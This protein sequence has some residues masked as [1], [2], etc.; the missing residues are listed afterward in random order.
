MATTDRFRVGEK[1][2]ID[3]VAYL[4]YT[5]FK[6]L[7]KFKEIHTQVKNLAPGVQDLYHAK[8]PKLNV[9]LLPQKPNNRA[10]LVWNINTH[11]I[12]RLGFLLSSKINAS[13]F[14]LKQYTLRLIS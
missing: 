4:K 11:Y 2:H 14:F 1:L 8:S 13:Y 3:K 10:A 5:Q 6:C 12:D 9:F 7:N